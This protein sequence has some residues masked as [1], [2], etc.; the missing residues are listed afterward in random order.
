[1]KRVLVCGAGG[2]IGNHLVK[3]LKE[4]GLWVRGVDLKHNEFTNTLADEFILGDLRD[5]NFVN[6]I[7]DIQF[8]EVYQLAADMGG[9]GYIFS[10]ENDANVMHNSA[11]INLNVAKECV[12]NKVSKVFYS[13]SACMYP[14]H[15]QIDPDNPNSFDCLSE[16][17]AL[18]RDE[19]VRVELT[20]DDAVARFDDRVID[21]SIGD[22]VEIH[23]AGA[24]FL[25]LKGWAKLIK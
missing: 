6:E 11:M 7:L 8:D 22:V 25:V 17:I 14:E 1:M 15:N 5:Q 18:S 10:G 13:S 21:A 2:F 24:T 20:V 23:E 19:I 4:E 12:N 3:F 16:G 9:A